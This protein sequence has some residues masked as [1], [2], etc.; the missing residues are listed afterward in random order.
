MLTAPEVFFMPARGGSGGQ[1]LCLHYRPPG[2][3]ARAA[4][5]YVHPF[6]EEMNKSRRMAA[7][8]SRALAAAGFA[9]LQ[10]D[11]LGCGDS[12][13]DFG[14]ATWAD[15]AQDVAEAAKWLLAI[16]AVPLW[17]WGLRAGCLVATE[18]ARTL[19]HGCNFMFWQPPLAGKVLLQQFLR[20][21]V[22][23][24]MLEGESKGRMK[25]LRERIAG[26]ETV[27]IAGY[28]LNPRLL[29]GL[30]AATLQTPPPGTQVVW[31]EVNSREPAGPLPASTAVIERW[32]AAGVRVSARTVQGPAF[33]QTSELEELP[34]LI[35][36]TGLSRFPA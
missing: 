3:S 32:Q 16:Y 7:L 18:A 13:G 6:A 36:A 25:A 14:D 29:N 9:V 17:L 11:L 22:A 27:E 31:T 20:L 23:G 24:D 28:R 10:I 35:D 12:S 34:A 15:W 4:V 1:R 19:G 21:K 30:E 2:G 26:G 5:V 33:W 8:Q